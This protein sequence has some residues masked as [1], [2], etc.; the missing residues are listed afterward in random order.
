MYFPT[1][2]RTRHFQ[3]GSVPVSL[4]TEVRGLLEEYSALYGDFRIR[5]PPENTVQV[6]VHVRRP[7]SWHRRRFHVTVNG[8][9]QFSP[10]RTESLIPY[11]EWAVNWGMARLLPQYLQL[12][13]A[14]LE[15]DGA[16]V[17]L[18]GA[19]GSGKSTLA[20]GLVAR[21]WRYL[22][23]EFALIHVG[24]RALHP[25]P[26]AICVKK[27]SFALVRSLGFQLR[28]KRRCVKGAKGPVGFLN[29]LGMRSDALGRACPVR[30]V[31]FPS[32]V[33]GARPSLIE[34]SRAEAGFALHQVCFNVLDCEAVA[35]DVLAA[36]VRRAWCY[37][38]IA[39]ELART[40]DLLQR[41]IA[42]KACA[43]GR[44]AVRGR[45]P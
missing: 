12:H 3:I 5:T 30:Y 9:L 36:V 35:T 23:D 1:Y 40:C 13:A 42:G 43:T 31:I 45:L 22:C 29:P 33:R 28:A 26:R 20:A 37:R 24:T 11:V 10:A 15:V 19:S 44:T 2:G 39:G 6:G 7:A 8:R 32:Y 18:A 27:P 25:Y 34:M 41:L 4:T 14:S 17:V 38:L 16:G 21:G